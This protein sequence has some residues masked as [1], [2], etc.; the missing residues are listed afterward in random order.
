M[1]VH[2]TE[3][4]GMGASICA[5]ICSVLWKTPHNSHSCLSLFLFPVFL[6]LFGSVH[7]FTSSWPRL[8]SK[9]ICCVYTVVYRPLFCFS[10]FNKRGLLHFF[11]LMSSKSHINVDKL[12][13]IQRITWSIICLR[14]QQNTLVFPNL[15]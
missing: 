7:V 12:T 15:L 13:S 11:K 14:R 5:L 3:S 10:R 6:I 2:G 8:N 9:Y 4:H 1:E